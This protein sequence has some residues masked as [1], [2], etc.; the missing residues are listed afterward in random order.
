M[1]GIFLSICNEEN[2]HYRQTSSVLEHRGPDLSQEFQI[3]DN[4][5][6]LS[7]GNSNYYGFFNRL[8]IRGSNEDQMQPIK[9]NDNKILF[10]NGEI[11]NTQFLI[12]NFKLDVKNKLLD[13]KD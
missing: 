12:D 11:Y 9:L 3:L 13:T 8:S 6:E 7:K 1:C 5:I 2:F 10:Y 4:K